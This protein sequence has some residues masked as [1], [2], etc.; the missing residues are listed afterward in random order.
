MDTPTAMPPDPSPWTPET[1]PVRLKVL[2]KLIEEFSEG[3]SA[4][5]RCIIQGVNEAEPVTGKINRVW[6]E[7]ELADALAN[8]RRTIESLGLDHERIN[9]RAERKYAYITRWLEGL[10]RPAEK[11]V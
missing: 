8:I 4:A 1:D 11:A 3:G 9:L 6:L 7:D 5:A 2:G 10:N